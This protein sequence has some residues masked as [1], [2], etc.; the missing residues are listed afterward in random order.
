MFDPRAAKL[1]RD[2]KEMSAT[3]AYV[4][5]LP[6]PLKPGIDLAVVAGNLPKAENH[7]HKANET[8]AGEKYNRT[9]NNSERIRIAGNRDQAS[10]SPE[11][12]K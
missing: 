8:Y 11:N 2:V 6:I 9:F 7:A 3:P 4:G 1:S 12:G 10:R 5:T